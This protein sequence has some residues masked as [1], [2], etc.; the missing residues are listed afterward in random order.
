VSKAGNSMSSSVSILPVVYTVLVFTNNVKFQNG[1]DILQN[2]LE[3]LIILI[4][5][6]I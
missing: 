1:I 6:Y 2:R 5:L 4:G 3:F